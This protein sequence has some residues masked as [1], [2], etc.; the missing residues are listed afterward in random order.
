MFNFMVSGPDTKGILGKVTSALASNGLNIIDMKSG[1]SPA[2]HAG[3]DLFTCFLTAGVGT[4]I[5][6]FKGP[7]DKNNFRANDKIENFAQ[8]FN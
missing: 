8:K 5:F 2:P 4:H 1:H 7:R 3:F 6:I